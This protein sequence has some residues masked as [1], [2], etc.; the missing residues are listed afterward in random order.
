MNTATFK[1]KN[2]DDV[3]QGQVA[4]RVKKLFPNGCGRILLVNIPQVGE[5]DFDLA[6]AKLKRYPCFPPYG[7]GLLSRDLRVAGYT[8][9]LIDLNFEVLS[10]VKD[11][12]FDY[13]RWQTMLEGA[14]ESFAPDLVGVSCMFSATHTSLRAVVDYTKMSFP[15]VPIVVGGVHASN[16]TRL[17]LEEI[18]NID[19]V[20]AYEADEAFVNFIDFANGKITEDRLT[21]TG[22]IDG[23]E[24]LYIERR[25]FPDGDKLNY[26]PDYDDL[27]L[28]ENGKWGE[29]GVYRWLIGNPPVSTILANRGCRAQCTFCSVHSFNGSGVR[30]RK[31]VVVV[32]EMERLAKHYGIKHFMWLDDDL[33]RP[34]CVEMFNEI[35]RR[36]LGITWDASNGVIASVTTK[37]VMRAAYESGCIGLSFGIESGDPEILKSVK[38][39]SGVKHFRRVGE[40]MK[41]YPSVFAKGFL[42]V[43]FPDET[44]GKIWNTIN[45]AREIELDWY[46]IQILSPFGGTAMAQT[47]VDRGLTDEH[48]VLSSKM[49]VGP[50]GGQRLKERRETELSA[51][52]P[53]VLDPSCSDCIPSREE[54]P[55]VWFM[56]DYLVNYERIARIEN[57]VKLSM[58]RLN[59]R[60]IIDRLPKHIALAALYLG[61]V[62]KKL[63]NYTEARG[64][65]EETDTYLE[66]SAFWR[67]RFEKLGL[68]RL[69]SEWR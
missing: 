50:A 47:M 45:L 15:G 1:I 57:P 22:I 42:M 31:S 51:F 9:R 61:I 36:N 48:T 65:F 69:L 16:N 14:V 33:F 19:A 8:T 49:F 11:E 52:N 34:D 3:I 67:V 23:G 25:I 38:K 29:I 58:Q 21:Q 41:E 2:S 60:A 12:V 24:Y 13:K 30:E 56:M 68:N 59:L 17:V 28:G 63:G 39:P 37:E 43:G 35:I 10:H 62:N 53:H 46:P 55:D 18:P 27:P 40:L 7:L 26:S 66:E 32:D 20:I 5:D 64:N 54:M 44:V 4:R 6:T